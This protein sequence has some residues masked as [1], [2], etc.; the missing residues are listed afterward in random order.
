MRIIRDSPPELLRALP[1]PYASIN[2]TFRPRRPKCQAVHAPNTPA[3]TTTTSY[4]FMIAIL[5][6]YQSIHPGLA[7]SPGPF[8][9]QPRSRNDLVLRVT[10][11]FDT[12]ARRGIGNRRRTLRLVHHLNGVHWFRLHPLNLPYPGMNWSGCA[13]LLPNAAIRAVIA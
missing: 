13:G 5:A 10:F 12:K 6:G 9:T 2:N 7:F 3:P 1:G 8:P 4:R 11:D